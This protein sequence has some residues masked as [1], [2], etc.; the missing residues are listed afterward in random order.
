MEGSSK[1]RTLS[2]VRLHGILGN[3]GNTHRAICLLEDLNTGDK[4]V[5]ELFGRAGRHDVYRMG[6]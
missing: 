6:P 5:V 3:D 2:L 1:K 4:E